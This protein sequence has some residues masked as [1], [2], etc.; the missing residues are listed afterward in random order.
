MSIA[1]VGPFIKLTN[2]T[3]LDT[4]CLMPM[5][6]EGYHCMLPALHAG[7]HMYPGSRK[8]LWEVIG[9]CPA[10]SP[11]GMRCCADEEHEG[12]HH[13]LTEGSNWPR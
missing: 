3:A 5:G 13:G 8:L 9:K 7:A 4:M 12:D 1:K 10:L 6:G 2:S 11:D